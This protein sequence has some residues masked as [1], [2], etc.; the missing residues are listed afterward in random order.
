MAINPFIGSALISGGSSLLGIGASHASTVYTNHANRDLYRE[1]YRD[2]LK[3]WNLQNQYNS[4]SAQ[5]ERLRSAGVNPASL[6]GAGNAMTVAAGGSTHP[7]QSQD[8]SSGAAGVGEALAG[9]PLAKMKRDMANSMQEAADLQNERT[10]VETELL[11]RKDAREAYMLSIEA[12]LKSGQTEVARRT[13]QKLEADTNLA[14]Q[15]YGFNEVYNPML[16]RSGY[17]SINESEARI[18]QMSASIAQAWYNAKENHRHNLATEELQRIATEAGVELSKAQVNHIN[19]QTNELVQLLPYNLSAAQLNNWISR[20]SLKLQ[21][22][23]LSLDKMEEKEREFA[24][25]QMAYEFQMQR[26]LDSSMIS[27]LFQAFGVRNGQS[28]VNALSGA[29]GAYFGSRLGR[30]SAPHQYAPSVSTRFYGR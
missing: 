25:V 11:K 8:Y 26:N 19:A 12:S 7:Y 16:L 28:V 2:S 4:P 9:L 20:N 14:N 1:Q 22:V 6:V 27:Q 10:G 5:I 23:K 18:N 15:Q 24:L 29:A 17:Q 30:G 21:Q 13:A 3:A